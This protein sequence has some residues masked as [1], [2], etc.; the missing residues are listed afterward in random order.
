MAVLPITI[1][2]HY[3]MNL[4]LQ[5][6]ELVALSSQQAAKKDKVLEQTASTTKTTTPQKTKLS[7]GPAP[8]RR[9][10]SRTFRYGYLVTT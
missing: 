6:K 5:V 4:S 1:S 9:C 2:Y 7:K 10:S 3:N 8:K